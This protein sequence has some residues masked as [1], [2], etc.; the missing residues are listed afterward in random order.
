PEYRSKILTEFKGQVKKLFI[1]TEAR[2]VLLEAYE[3]SNVKQR[4]SL[5][6]EFYGPEFTLFKRTENLNIKDLIAEDPSNKDKVLKNLFQAIQYLIKKPESLNYI[7]MHRI[8]LE[9]FTY[10]DDSKIREVIE[11]ISEQVSMFLHTREGSQVAMLCF[12][13]GAVKDRKTMLKSMK[14]YAA[15]ICKEE[16][17]YLVLLRAFDVVD[18]TVSVTKYIIDQIVKPGVLKTIMQDKFGHRVILYLLTGRAK[19]KMYLSFETFQLL[20]KGD[21]IREKT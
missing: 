17:G 15:K 20:E 21:E 5:L 19:S 8:L 14:E 12:S 1:H 2:N 16:Y 7:I 3:L 18:D 11:M 13:H 10:A 9:Y 6:E 4:S